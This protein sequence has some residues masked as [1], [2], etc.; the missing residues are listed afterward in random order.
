[1][2]GARALSDGNAGGV[3]RAG[4]WHIPVRFS[5]D[6]D[7]LPK[8]RTVHYSETVY[9]FHHGPNPANGGKYEYHYGPHSVS[10]SRVEQYLDPF[11]RFRAE[12]DGLS[13][14][15]R[16]DMDDLRYL[17]T[18]PESAVDDAV[19]GVGAARNELD[20]AT[21]SLGYATGKSGLVRNISI[22]VANAGA[23]ALAAGLL[24]NRD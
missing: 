15:F 1:M 20:D 17:G 6:L 10:R 12:H 2:T 22:G 18:R 11:D 3:V 9:D 14:A 16:D 7:A 19:E 8:E 4:E 5:E 13:A 21:R 24:L 23:G